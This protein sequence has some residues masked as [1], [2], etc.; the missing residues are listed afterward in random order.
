M[1]LSRIVCGIVAPILLLSSLS[2]AETVESPAPQSPDVS[3]L[4]DKQLSLLPSLALLEGTVGFGGGIDLVFHLGS[5]FYLG[6]ESGFYRW[7]ESASGS[8]S[9]SVS[10]SS[11]PLMLT[12]LYKWVIPESAFRPFFGVAVGASLTMGNLSVSLSGA[13]SSYSN[14]AINF[15]ALARPGLEIL[16]SPTLSVMIEPK[17]GI[18]DS[19][20]VFLPQAGV[21]F[22]L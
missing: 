2:F 9:A 8:V 16:L 19:S 11:L 10:V 20:F 21:G 17:L 5:H 6:A 18:L 15:E 7:S 14:T 1:K 13:S 4:P 12:A 22:V 3:E